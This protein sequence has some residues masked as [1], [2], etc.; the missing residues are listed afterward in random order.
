MNSSERI[1]KK[2]IVIFSFEKFELLDNEKFFSDKEIIF[3][4]SL[5]G[6]GI[7]FKCKY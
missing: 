5:E 6:L 1:I 4:T 2:N 3:F 7:S